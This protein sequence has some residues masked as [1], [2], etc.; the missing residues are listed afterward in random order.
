MFLDRGSS[1]INGMTGT[2]GPLCWEAIADAL[3]LAEP[4]GEAA[5]RRS[6]KTSIGP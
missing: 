6:M 5:R 4:M 3:M 2:Q 1:T